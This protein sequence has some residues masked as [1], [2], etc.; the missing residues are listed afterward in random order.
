MR[1]VADKSLSY[2]INIICLNQLDVCSAHC[3]SQSTYPKYTG[4][5][6][7]SPQVLRTKP[8]QKQKLLH[9]SELPGL[10]LY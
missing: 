1:E 9:H 5:L 3:A 8:Q 10:R 2:Y 6:L 7:P 4:L